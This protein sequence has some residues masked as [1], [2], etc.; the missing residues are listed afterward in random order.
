VN[1]PN[2]LGLITAG[3]VLFVIIG[4]STIVFLAERHCG[5]ASGYYG[6]QTPTASI[7]K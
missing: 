2:A 6:C 5:A 3:A 7:S 1:R 4:L